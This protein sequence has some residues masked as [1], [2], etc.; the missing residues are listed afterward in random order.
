M[1]QISVFSLFRLK[2]E[3]VFEKS[4]EDIATVLLTHKKEP[5]QSL[6]NVHC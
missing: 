1:K 5:Q 6:L 3:R 2:T 4:D